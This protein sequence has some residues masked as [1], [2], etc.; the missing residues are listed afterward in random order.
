MLNVN[1][2]EL[3]RKFKEKDWE[4]VFDKAG[5]ISDF[6]I[7]QKFKIHDQCARE[8]LRQEC[9]INLW[10]KVQAGKCDP[11]RNLFSFIWQNS[12]FRILE[13]LRKENHRKKIVRFV[14]FEAEDYITFQRKIGKKYVPQLLQEVWT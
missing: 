13:V 4:Y 8:D 11:E 12:T 6:I 10:N 1:K 3:K 5:R 7:F 2:E 9:L 14:P